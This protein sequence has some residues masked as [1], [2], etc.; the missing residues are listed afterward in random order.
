MSC[1]ESSNTM[2]CVHIYLK[3]RVHDKKTQKNWPEPLVLTLPPS[4]GVKVVTKDSVKVTGDGVIALLGHLRSCLSGCRAGTG[5]ERG[6][7]CGGEQYSST[8]AENRVQST[9]YRRGG[10]AA[11]CWSERQRLQRLEITTRLWSNAL[12]ISDSIQKEG[13]MKYLR[14]IQNF[15]FDRL[16]HRPGRPLR[17]NLMSQYICFS[18][19]GPF[20]VCFEELFSKVQNPGGFFRKIVF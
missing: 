1:Q 12:V 5:S 3:K 17:I 8:A 19:I 15:M 10:T 6:S 4:T 11:A 18:Q 9:E 20:D 7:R 14:D 16:S 13:D 2:V